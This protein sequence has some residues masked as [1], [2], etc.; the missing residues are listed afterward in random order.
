[1]Q[2]NA[3]G[4]TLRLTLGCML[5]EKLGI[6]LH[7]VGGGTRRTFTTTGEAKLSA[8]MDENCG[9]MLDGDKPAVGHRSRFHRGDQFAAESRP[10]S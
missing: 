8:W 2:G 6:E 4:S 1:M 3:Y 10:E 5:A 7:R 9:C